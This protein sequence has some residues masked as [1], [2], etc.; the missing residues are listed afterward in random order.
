MAN[1]CREAAL[2]PIRSITDIQHVDAEQVSLFYKCNIITVSMS[3]FVYI[4]PEKPRWGEVN[5]IHTHNVMY[6][7]PCPLSY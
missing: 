2:G 3:L 4:G 6:A 1:L 7:S 5:Y